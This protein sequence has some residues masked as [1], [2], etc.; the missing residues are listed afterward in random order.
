MRSINVKRL[1]ITSRR[2]KR[3]AILRTLLLVSW[4]KHKHALHPASREPW[5]SLVTSPLTRTLSLR[6]AENAWYNYFLSS[7][8]SVTRWSDFEEANGFVSVAFEKWKLRRSLLCCARR[9]GIN[10]PLL[11]SCRENL[12]ERET[13]TWSYS[14]CTLEEHLELSSRSKDA[15]QLCSSSSSSSST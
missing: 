4:I 6:Y 3:S 8:S 14:Y 7:F 11:Q 9:D 13:P 2:W 15:M 1:R 10:S 12:F 5:A